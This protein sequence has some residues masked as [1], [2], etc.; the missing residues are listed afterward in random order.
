M[1]LDLTRIISFFIVRLLRLLIVNNHL[2]VLNGNTFKILV[3]WRKKIE[4]RRIAIDSNSCLDR[5]VGHLWDAHTGYGETVRNIIDPFAVS[6]TAVTVSKVRRTKLRGPEQIHFRDTNFFSQ[7]YNWVLYKQ[8]WHEEKGPS[9]IIGDTVTINR[10][11]PNGLSCKK[12]FL[13]TRAWKLNEVVVNEL[14]ISRIRIISIFY[15]GFWTKQIFGIYR[16][17]KNIRFWAM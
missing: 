8:D 11:R 7:L 10:G 13:G 2:F 6:S 17:K 4:Q 12:L 3:F 5:P 1:Y 14:S 15:S 9:A 16:V